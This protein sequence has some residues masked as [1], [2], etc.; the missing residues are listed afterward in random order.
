MYYTTSRKHAVFVMVFR[1]IHNK[2]DRELLVTSLHNNH[3][4]VGLETGMSYDLLTG[5]IDF[6]FEAHFTKRLIY[7]V[8]KKWRGKLFYRFRHNSAS[9]LAS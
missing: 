6:W 1:C 7:I 3:A 5:R 9:F 2:K 8:K 4:K